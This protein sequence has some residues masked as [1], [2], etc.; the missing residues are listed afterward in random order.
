MK[1]LCFCYLGLE[2]ALTRGPVALIGGLTPATHAAVRSGAVALTSATAV[3]CFVRAIPVL[4]EGWQFVAESIGAGSIA[5]VA[6]VK[7][8]VRKTA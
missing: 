4:V 6:A 3:F 2:L 5:P 8:S 7:V 1:C